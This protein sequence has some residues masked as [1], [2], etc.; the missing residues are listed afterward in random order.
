MRK[1]DPRCPWILLTPS[2][3]LPRWELKEI[4]YQDETQSGGNHN[5]YVTVL[6]ENGA[7]QSGVIVW[8]KWPGA[9]PHEA[10]QGTLSGSTDFGIYGG[11]F[12]PDR[13]ERG[14]YRCYVEDAAVSDE[15][16]GIGLPANRHVNYLLTFQRVTGEMP[17]INGGLTEAQ[18]RDIARDEI[19]RARIVVA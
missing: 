3:A 12:Y 19:G 16:Y 5:I 14:A 15:V 1:I 10:Q 4:V 2:A 17:P 8:Q 9:E 7:P 13:G 18:V 11:A 6:D